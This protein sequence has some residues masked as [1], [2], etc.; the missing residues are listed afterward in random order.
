MLDFTNPTWDFPVELQETYDRTGRKIEGNRVV[1]RTDTG[2]HMS[3]GLGDKYKIITH[4]NVVNSIMDSIDDVANTLGTAYEEKIHII[5][6]GRKLRG[7]INFPDWKIEPVVDDICTF[8]IQFYNS[9]DASWAFQQSAEAF[10]LWCLNGCTTPNTVAKTWAKHTTNVSVL[11]SSTK[12]LKGFEAFK[13]SDILFKSYVN[14][15]ISNEDAERFINDALCKVKQR[16]NP[17]HPHYNKSRREDLL[18]MWDNNRAN[19]GN[20]QWALY[21]TLTEWAT[22]TDHL[23]NPENARRLRENEIAK[24]MNSNRWYEL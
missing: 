22:H 18:R 14:Y 9:Y 21:N 19:I 6:G 23:G 13:E 16:G 20:N 3:R 7:E 2:E 10:R 8:R 5:D 24:A 12:I 1:V 11:A 15:K 17:D 4:S